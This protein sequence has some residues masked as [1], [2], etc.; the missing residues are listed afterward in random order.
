MTT[1]NA[2]GGGYEGLHRKF[3]EKLPDGVEVPFVISLFA[4]AGAVNDPVYGKR[5]GRSQ[6]N[7]AIMD[8]PNNTYNLQ[9]NLGRYIEVKGNEYEIWH[10]GIRSR[11]KKEY[12][13]N[14]VQETAPFLMDGDRVKLG[15]FPL[16]Q[17]INAMSFSTFIEN[18]ITYSYCRNQADLKYR[19]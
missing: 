16:K 12:V 19:K 10:N 14:T 1:K 13:L 3:L 7:I 15:R 5:T 17:S 18:L 2:S 6:L 11:M 8:K 4:T 9:V